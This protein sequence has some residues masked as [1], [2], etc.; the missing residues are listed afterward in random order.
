MPVS[1]KGQ[2]SDDELSP[3]MKKA[4][5]P[6]VGEP[7]GGLSRE[8]ADRVNA[9]G[10]GLNVDEDRPRPGAAGGQK[11]KLFDEPELPDPK[12]P[13]KD[14][15]PAAGSPKLPLKDEDPA[16]DPKLPLKDDPKPAAEGKQTGENTG[17][18]GDGTGV[19][20]S[21]EGAAGK[22]QKKG[23]QTDSKAAFG[24]GGAGMNA[25]KL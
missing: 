22:K 20:N 2:E 19:N 7:G 18:G 14:E 12:L 16:A 3:S 15:D 9:L 4:K 1:P 17:F 25:K 5:K 6:R 13:L 24:G 11:N 8:E 21:A 23:K 10:L